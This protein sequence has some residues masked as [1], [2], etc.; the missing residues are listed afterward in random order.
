MAV[1]QKKSPVKS[2]IYSR[3]RQVLLHDV[4]VDVFV[5]AVFDVFA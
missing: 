2:E 4:N 3:P 1:R 5:D